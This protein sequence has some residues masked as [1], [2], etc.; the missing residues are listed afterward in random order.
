[1]TVTRPEV[2]DELMAG[3]EKPEDLLCEEG[4]FEHLKKAAA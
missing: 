1:M 2:L 3:Y 4:L